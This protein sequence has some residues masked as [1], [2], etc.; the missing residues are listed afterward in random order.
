MSLQVKICGL[1][2]PAAVD[3]A[4]EGGAAFIGLM[5]FPASPRNVDLDL[6]AQLAEPVR[7]RARIVAVTVD[8]TDVALD[9]L[10]EALRPDVIQLHGAE[11]PQRVREAAVRTGAQTIKVFPVTTAEDLAPVAAFEDAADY[12]MFDARPPKDL[13]RPGG[14]GA[15]FDWTLLAGRHFARPWF[16]AGGLTPANVRE[17]AGAAGAALVDVSSGVE[18]AP[19]LKDAALITAFLAAARLGPAPQFILQRDR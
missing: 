13:G 7:G 4:L 9:A 12:L 14:G 11:T 2:T 16:L 1:S 5:F 6:A 10:R 8:P 18:Q 17:A 15:P 3:A 19:G